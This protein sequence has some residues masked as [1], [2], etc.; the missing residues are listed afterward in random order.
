[1]FQNRCKSFWC[2]EYAATDK[3]FKSYTYQSG[4]QTVNRVHQVFHPAKDG[5][6]VFFS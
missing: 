4:S 6:S 5:I 2:E 3:Q 1:L